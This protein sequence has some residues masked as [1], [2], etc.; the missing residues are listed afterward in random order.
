MSFTTNHYY[1]SEYYDRILSQYE[2]QENNSKNTPR[3]E[4]NNNFHGDNMMN[5]QIMSAGTQQHFN[6]G[7]N[8]SYGCEAFHGYN[9]YYDDEREAQLSHYEPQVNE[10]QLICHRFCFSSVCLFCCR[11][12]QIN[13][14]LS[15]VLIR[16]R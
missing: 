14:D 12:N 1:S 7:Y 10:C 16:Q 2:Q 11:Q 3:N 4:F 5:T 15:Q 8:Q 9:H 6:Y 13:G